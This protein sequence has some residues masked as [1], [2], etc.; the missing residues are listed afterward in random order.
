MTPHERPAPPPL[1]FELA[2]GMVR[3]KILG[4]YHFVELLEYL[5][6]LNRTAWYPLSERIGLEVPLWRRPNQLN[7]WEAR[8]YEH[9]LVKALTRELAATPLPALLVDC[10]ADVGLLSGLLASHCPRIEEIVALEPNGEAFP[11]LARNVARWPLLTRALQVAVADYDGCG[12]LRQP[13]YQTS[14]HSA[15]VEADATGAIDVTRIDR[16]EIDV[17]ARCLALKIDVEGGELAV[18]AGAL[19]T[20]RRARRWVVTVEAHRKVFERT[21]VDPFEPV[22]LL[23]KAG[24]ARAYLAEQPGLLL[25]WRKSY[26]EQVRDREIGNLVAVSEF[27]E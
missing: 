4:G 17:S 27:S 13:D 24:I 10:G 7:L 14:P 9:S 21:G 18:I 23:E 16:L 1:L 2:R 15:Y 26:F 22:R 8:H 25:D 19:E 5:G 11:I 3:R 6:V 12:S 20:L